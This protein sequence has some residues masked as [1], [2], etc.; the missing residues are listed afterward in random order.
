MKKMIVTLVAMMAVTFSFAETNSNNVDRR[1]DMSCNMDGRSS[2]NH[3]R[4]LQQRTEITGFRKRS[5]PET[6][7]SPGRKEGRSEDEERAEQGAVW[8]LHAHHAEHPAQQTTV[9]KE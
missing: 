3:P 9:R 5:Y 7:G 1:F 8:S 2:R 6:H 4:Q